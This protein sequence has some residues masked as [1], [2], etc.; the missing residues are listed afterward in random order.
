MALIERDIP[1]QKLDAALQD[2]TAGEGRIALVCGEAGIGK[3]S[4]VEQFTQNQKDKCRVLWGA[5]D[6]LFTPRPLGPLHDIARQANGQ[7]EALLRSEKDRPAIFS[8]CLNE[9]L[10]PTII[11]FEDIHWADEAT[12]DLIKFLGRRMQHTRS[13]LIATYR[14]DELGPQHPLRLLLGDLVSRSST[15]RLG[16]TSLSVDAVGQ[17]T[18]NR[19]LDAEALHQLTGGNPFFVTEIL[20]CEDEGIPAT[21]RDAVLARAARLSLSGRAVLNAAAVIGTRIEPW[22]LAD[23]TRAE[24]AGNR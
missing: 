4:L 15:R 22:L 21:I 10:A 2:A 5:C 19:A 3:T 9:L 18:G 13:L 24:A 12:L 20:A 23:V 17:L 7:L 11:V 16:L 14:N 1:L 6:D 8:A